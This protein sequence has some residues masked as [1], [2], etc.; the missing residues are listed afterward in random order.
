MDEYFFLIMLHAIKVPELN[1]AKKRSKRTIA[2]YLTQARFVR[3]EPQQE[4]PGIN[5]PV[6]W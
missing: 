3:F 1:F 6:L 2:Q 5:Q 4:I